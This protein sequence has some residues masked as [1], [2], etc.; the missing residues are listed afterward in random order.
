MGS[1]GINSINNN[2]NPTG[3]NNSSTSSFLQ[4]TLQY[5]ASNNFIK[6]T[7]TALVTNITNNNSANVS[8][9]SSTTGT[10]NNSTTNNPGPNSSATANQQLV[11]N[12]RQTILR[13]FDK[14]SNGNL[15]NQEVFDYIRLNSSRSSSHYLE[16]LRLLN[17]NTD[18]IKQI[19]TIFQ[20]PS[21]RTLSDSDIA[22]GIEHIN[23]NNITLNPLQLSLL[24]TN[25]NYENIKNKFDEIDLDNNHTLSEQETLNNILRINSISNNAERNTIESILKTNS[26]YTFLDS[27]VK[28][29]DS[30]RNGIIS[31][32][33]VNLILK[34]TLEKGLSTIQIASLN[35]L[36]DK[37][38]NSAGLRQAFEQKSVKF[39]TAYNYLSAEIFNASLGM[40]YDKDLPTNATLFD[41]L[42]KLNTHFSTT[43]ISSNLPSSANFTPEIR[44]IYQ[45]F[46]EANYGNSDFTSR[47][48][49]F[50]EL[51]FI[52]EELSKNFKFT[53]TN[54]KIPTEKVQE[55]KS[56][57][58]QLSEYNVLENGKTIRNLFKDIAEIF[59][60][61]RNTL[62]VFDGVTG[63]I[64]KDIVQNLGVNNLDTQK[65]DKYILNRLKLTLTQA[66][67]IDIS[68]L[69]NL[70]T[71]IDTK[72]QVK[73]LTDSYIGQLITGDVDSAEIIKSDLAAFKSTI[74]SLGT[75]SNYDKNISIHHRFKDLIDG[76]IASLDRGASIPISNKS[77]LLRLAE[78]SY[79]QNSVIADSIASNI[80]GPVNKNN[81]VQLSS[82]LKYMINMIDSELGTSDEVRIKNELSALYNQGEMN[83][84]GT[85]VKTPTRNTNQVNLKLVNG[86]ILHRFLKGESK[87]HIF[88][89]LGLD[90]LAT[91]KNEIYEKLSDFKL[92]FNSQYFTNNE[93]LKFLADVTN[94]DNPNFQNIGTNLEVLYNFENI[95]NKIR[96][97]ALASNEFTALEF[98]NL[99]SNQDLN[100]ND[101]KQVVDGTKD[102]GTNI[103]YKLVSDLKN[104]GLALDFSNRPGKL[105]ELDIYFIQS[106]F[107]NAVGI[108][109]DFNIEGANFSQAASALNSSISNFQKGDVNTVLK[110]NKDILLSLAKIFKEDATLSN[111]NNIETIDYSDL[112]AK[113]F[114]KNDSTFKLD[115]KVSFES[116]SLMRDTVNNLFISKSSN[117]ESYQ[118]VKEMQLIYNSSQK[119][120]DQISLGGFTNSGLKA[121][122]NMAGL[123]EYLETQNTGNFNFET[124]KEFIKKNFNNNNLSNIPLDKKNILAITQFSTQV[125]RTSLKP[126]FD[127]NREEHYSN[128]YSIKNI[129]KLVNDSLNVD[130]NFNLKQLFDR[131]KPFDSSLQITVDASNNLNIAPEE[132]LVN[133][134]YQKLKSINS[135]IKSDTP[136]NLTSLGTLNDSLKSFFETNKSTPGYLE[137]SLD[138]TFNPEL[139]KKE[140]NVNTFNTLQ[141]KLTLVKENITRQSNWSLGLVLKSFASTLRERFNEADLDNSNGIITH[142]YQELKRANPNISINDVINNNSLAQ[143]DKIL[144][145]YLKYNNF[146]TS[147]IS[148]KTLSGAAY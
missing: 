101:L 139:T 10:S 107:K 73:T 125:Q 131:F 5:S 143:L 86:L 145:K 95:N 54:F 94:F 127:S 21:S 20:K 11:L 142:L 76:F 97:G 65:V 74:S 129:H 117:L 91:Q 147:S 123:I 61:T 71:Q 9:N 49:E 26:Q 70:K 25:T 19:F 66:E 110:T 67:R 90:L 100:A 85:Y 13:H 98:L 17:P 57:I 138:P 29:Y 34:G 113:A 84:I 51:K 35:N 14:D 6:R 69:T 137:I 92:K 78:T 75:F 50:A 136:M 43:A 47:P 48:I 133:S 63:S 144:F 111:S 96:L 59:G 7:R 79:G 60:D 77:E 83:F 15:D 148:N 87:D 33:E 121:K 134:L 56:Y 132:S 1:E 128:I 27:I 115:D 40:F 58:Q 46:T 81:L 105:S 3:T 130:I 62:G 18:A 124:L 104:K 122:P 68:N 41:V 31:D 120:Y 93:A 135:S 82:N 53:D 99:L 38:R 2:T 118:E 22:K 114:Q 140:I 37:N 23:L 112:L 119:L 109:A 52:Q 72:N 42:K 126:F 146:S 30:D 32:A 141:S 16:A 102:S 12:L 116:L 44:E 39:S 36:I 89:E 4:N 45:K 106:S 24:R 80:N 28:K 64:Q 8:N 88:R 55:Y 108:K 103:F